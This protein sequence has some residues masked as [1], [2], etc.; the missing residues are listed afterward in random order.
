LANKNERFSCFDIATGQFIKHWYSYCDLRISYNVLN[1]GLMSWDCE[2]SFY[3]CTNT[4]LLFLGYCM[5]VYVPISFR[6][7]LANHKFVNLFSKQNLK[8]Y[9]CIYCSNMPMVEEIQIC[10]TRSD[11]SCYWNE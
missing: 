5:Y 1:I 9:P 7:W 6:S 2:G 3:N 11:A 10:I 8:L 4:C